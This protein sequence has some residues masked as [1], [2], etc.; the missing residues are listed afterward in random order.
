MP[1][2]ASIA[3][4]N[5]SFVNG[6]VNVLLAAPVAVGVLIGSLAGPLVLLRSTPASIRALFIVVMLTFGVEMIYMG[7]AG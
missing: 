5:S 1:T 3:P 4:N 6:F 2:C 7:V